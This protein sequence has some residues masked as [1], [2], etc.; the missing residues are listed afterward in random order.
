M[1]KSI[2]TKFENNS[3][4]SGTPSECRHHL[5]FGTGF[6]RMAEDDGLWVPLLNKEHN[7]SPKGTIYQIHGNPAAEK[8]SKML[9]QAS[10]ET[11]LLAEALEEATG[12]SAEE[13]RNRARKAFMARYGQSWM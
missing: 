13:W 1:S 7:M 10:W 6:R 5:V 12:M 11:Q 3:V 8:L 4:F 2:V 9:G